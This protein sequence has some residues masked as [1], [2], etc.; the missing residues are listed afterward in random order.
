VS[1]DADADDLFGWESSLWSHVPVEFPPARE[2]ADRHYPRETHGAK[3]ILAPGWRFLFYRRDSAGAAVWGV[4]RN[5]FKRRWYWRNSLFR[6]E[7]AAL[8]SSLIVAATALTYDVWRRR[9]KSLPYERLI[10]EV[11]IVATARRRSKRSPPGQCYLMAGWEHL[12]DLEP[13]HGRPARAV[14][15][16]PIPSYPEGASCALSVAATE[17]EPASQLS[18]EL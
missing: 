10:T 15:A 18:L 11:D 16:A 8:S 7:S 4:V 5:R 14:L 12:Y 17:D 3:G 6:N 1:A 13:G 9:Y 2:L